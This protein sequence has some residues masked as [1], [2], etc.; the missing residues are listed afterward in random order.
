[1]VDDMLC[2][3]IVVIG[4]PGDCTGPTDLGEAKLDNGGDVNPVV[5]LVVLRERLPNRVTGIEGCVVRLAMFGP[6][7]PFLA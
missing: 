5:P 3:D 2:G 1:M 6:F 7:C 4:G